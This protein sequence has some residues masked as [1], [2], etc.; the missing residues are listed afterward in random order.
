MK[1]KYSAP[2]CLRKQMAE[3]LFSSVFVYCMPVWGGIGKEDLRDIQVLQNKAARIV[4]HSP[5]MGVSRNDI[6]NQIN[7]LTLNQLIEYHTLVTIY[8]I[9]K[10]KEPEYLYNILSDENIRRKINI[11]NENLTLT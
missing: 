1:F 5:L 8:K 7:W 11:K 3:G 6:F 4:M 2:F 9:K 10:K